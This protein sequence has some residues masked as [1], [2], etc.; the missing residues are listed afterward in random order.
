MPF[1]QVIF[2][3]VTDNE[4]AQRIDNFLLK[5]LKK[6][7]KSRIYRIIR[8]GEVRVN[9]KRIKAKYK[10]QPGDEI[11]IPPIRLEESK[12]KAIIPQNLLDQIHSAILFE[13][14]HL[15]AI[16]KPSGLSVHSGSNTEFGL[17]EIVRKLRKDHGYLELV[18]RLDKETSGVILIAKSRQVLQELHELL[19]NGHQIQKHYIALVYGEWTRGK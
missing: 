19:R 18:H 9:K 3:T 14:A 10:L 13:D 11:R 17:I 7:P 4:N 8:K 1:N 5:Y 16:N 6:I 12:P 2:Y 15:M